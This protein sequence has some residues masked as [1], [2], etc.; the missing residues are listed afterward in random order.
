MRN[1]LLLSCAVLCALS[2]QA[3]AGPTYTWTGASGTDSNWS[4][5]GNW[6]EGYVPDAGSDVLFTDQ[7]V[8]PSLYAVTMDGARRVG[9]VTFNIDSDF[10]ISG[11]ANT[12]YSYYFLTVNGDISVMSTASDHTY[13]VVGSTSLSDGSHLITVGTGQSL[14]FLAGTVSGAAFGAST[15]GANVNL[16]IG[17]GGQVQFNRYYDGTNIDCNSLTVSTTTTFSNGRLFINTFSDPNQNIRWDNGILFYGIYTNGDTTFDQVMSGTT[18]VTKLN[19]GTMTITGK[20]T[21]VSGNN[22]SGINIAY[23]NLR[24][25]GTAM[26]HIGDTTY[27]F[28]NS[29]IFTYNVTY[30]CRGS[31]AN[32]FQLIGDATSTDD[33]TETIG[34]ICS[35]TGVAQGSGGATTPNVLYVDVQHGANANAV[36]TLTN[37]LL[38]NPGNQSFRAGTGMLIFTGTLGDPDGSGFYNRV[39]VTNKLAQFVNGSWGYGIVGGD[40]ASYDATRGII[41][42]SQAVTL[43]NYTRDAILDDQAAPITNSAT[44]GSHVLVNAALAGPLARSFTIGSLKIDGGYDFNLGNNNLTI[45]NGGLIKSGAASVITSGTIYLPNNAL[46]IYNPGDL[47]ISSTIKFASTS[48]DYMTKAGAGKLTLN[49]GLSGAT[50]VNLN[51]IEGDLTIGTSGTVTLRNGAPATA[52]K[53]VYNGG[54]VGNLILGRDID[55]DY[56]FTGGFDINSG[57][58]LWCWGSGGQPP[59]NSAPIRMGTGTVNIYAPATLRMDVN[60]NNSQGRPLYGT[61]I[62]LLGGTM[63]MSGKGVLG[64][65]T[66][67]NFADSFTSTLSYTAGSG[68]ANIY[69]ISGAGT[70][71]IT[72]SGTGTAG[73]AEFAFTSLTGTNNPNGS[74][75]F[76]GNIVLDTNTRLKVTDAGSW[77]VNPA[78][79]TLQPGSMLMFGANTVIASQT[80]AGGG[81]FHMNSNLTTNSSYTLTAQGLTFAPSG[82]VGG[83]PAGAGILTLRGNLTLSTTYASTLAV[84]LLHGTGPSAQPVAGTDYDQFK[85]IRNL[86]SGGVLATAGTTN[87]LAGLDL[88]VNIAA[89]KNFLGNVM[90]LVLS[91]STNLNGAALHGVTFNNTGFADI[92]VGGTSTAGG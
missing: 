87:Q 32:R 43:G 48:A 45:Q 62:N 84:D 49:G 37:G 90:T 20:I 79:T 29:N 68:T 60:F 89:K 75:R 8:T 39:M 71:F 2:A 38:T 61:N 18:T 91:G 55:P 77:P 69:G 5:P 28:G 76:T 70:M 34:G 44:V 21:S 86:T 64:N 24:V 92:T 16:T 27:V 30:G 25:T 15:S 19:P 26:D 13:R 72:G 41:P 73:S 52:G 46:L 82:T 9:N 85:I 83:G 7:G 63:I 78:S 66:N 58:V 31:S 33:A 35:D 10:A 22:A 6:L 17:G 59:N 50:G 88:S 4:T 53:L 65:T 54:P 36:L 3:F 23:G 40:F 80:F 57:T 12:T 51:W 14:L 67:L 47:T 11:K 81:M 74:A 1:V 42:L 56:L